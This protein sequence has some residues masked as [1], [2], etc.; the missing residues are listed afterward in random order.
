MTVLL[1]IVVSLI[2]NI[3][4]LSVEQSRRLL[5]VG[6]ALLAFFPAIGCVTLFVIPRR[7]SIYVPLILS[8]RFIDCKRRPC[9]VTHSATL[10]DGRRVSQGM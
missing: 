10:A 5:G 6:G 2:A 9:G 4:R 7:A 1:Y 8:V 3:G